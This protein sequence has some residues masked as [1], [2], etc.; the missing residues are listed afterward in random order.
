MSKG[1]LQ[2]LSIARAF[3]SDAEFIILDEPT[4]SLDPISEKEIYEKCMEIFRGRT[5]L[6]I[7][8]RLGAVKN[9]DEILVLNGG[10]A[11]ES[12]THESLMERN[13]VYRDLYMTQRSLYIDEK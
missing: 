8:H 5:V 11:V 6:F 9:M 4:A 13:G 2:K 12:G 10:K 3:L 7:T 1:Q